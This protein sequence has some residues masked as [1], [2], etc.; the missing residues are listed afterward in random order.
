MSLLWVFFLDCCFKFLCFKKLSKFFSPGL[1]SCIL[2]VKMED[3]EESG[4]EGGGR[5]DRD[6]DYM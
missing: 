5:E 3:P 2:K 4:G 6:G 1:L